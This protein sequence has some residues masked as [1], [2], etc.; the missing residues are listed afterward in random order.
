MELGPTCQPQWPLNRPHRSLTRA[1][2]RMVTQLSP[3]T[4]GFHRPRTR[5]PHLDP[6]WRREEK[7]VYTPLPPHRL[8]VRS[9][10]RC[11]ALHRSPLR[12]PSPVTDE[13]PPSCPTGPKEAPHHHAPPAP[14]TCV[15]FLR[16]HP[17]VIFLREHPTVIF[18]REHPTCG[19][20]LQLFP[21]SAPSSVSPR[22]SSPTTSPATSLS[23]H[24]AVEWL[25]RWASL[26][27][28]PLI[29]PPLVQ[30][31]SPATP[32]PTS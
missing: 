6:L 8:Y 28:K 16:E 30:V 11:S 27:T 5:L 32:C 29:E 17:T 26:C 23:M 22:S 13:P 25:L 3:Y 24:A 19:S 1:A 2:P 15:I 12:P 14:R 9:A 7:V 21:D 10:P 4:A 20:L 18:L 31:S